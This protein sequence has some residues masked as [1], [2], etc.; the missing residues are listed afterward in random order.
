[1][2]GELVRDVFLLALAQC[3]HMITYNAILTASSLRNIGSSKFVS[4]PYACLR[5]TINKPYQNVCRLCINAEFVN[6]KE[7][8]LRI[9][10][11]CFNQQNS[12]YPSG[13]PVVVILLY[14]LGRDHATQNTS[15]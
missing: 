13:Q 11:L 7:L 8:L 4:K 15:R 5:S 3:I 9:T 6:L 14:G 12:S 1:M 2:K 10:V